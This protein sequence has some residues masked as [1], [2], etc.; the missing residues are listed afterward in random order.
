[1][2]LGRLAVV[3]LAAL[4]S[5]IAVAPA[6]A[7]TW[8]AAPSSA[9]ADLTLITDA[10]GVGRC[11]VRPD[12]NQWVLVGPKVVPVPC[13]QPH[14]ARTLAFVDV[15]SLNLTM[16]FAEAHLLLHQ[17]TQARLRG[18]KPPLATLQALAGWRAS[19]VPAYT[20]CQA[21]MR[22]VLGLSDLRNGG[23]RRTLFQIDLTGPTAA[24][25]AAGDRRAR[26]DV[27]RFLPLDGTHSGYRMLPLPTSLTGVGDQ[28]AH[29]YCAR[30]EQGTLAVRLCTSP[31]FN[32][33][34]RG[35]WLMVHDMVPL[36]NWPKPMSLSGANA[37]LV[38][39]CR[40]FMRDHVASSAWPLAA[41]R[42]RVRVFDAA[43]LTGTDALTAWG[44]SAHRYSCSL[45]SG[46][47]VE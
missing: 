6:Q 21:E 1:M 22:R 47:Y 28:F 14:Q 41:S 31:S 38:S 4:S 34:V 9:A 16:S 10:P 36:P 40:F 43:T 42:V 30:S 19:L 46:L 32:P 45:P 27:V 23:V 3:L 7:E 8:G 11:Y 24:R 33:E 13:A 29:Q 35:A 2:R 12:L 20:V 17:V 25:W 44:S 5:V 18:E 39:L 15:S 37:Q 26:C